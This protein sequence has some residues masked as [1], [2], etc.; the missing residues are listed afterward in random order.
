V[1][2]SGRSKGATM[3]ACPECGVEMR[4]ETITKHCKLKHKVTGFPLSHTMSNVLKIQGSNV[5]F[6]PNAILPSPSENCTFFM[7]PGCADIYSTQNCPPT[8]LENFPLNFHLLFFPLFL[9]FPSFIMFSICGDSLSPARRQ[10]IPRIRVFFR[11][12]VYSIV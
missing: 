8:T 2:G 4:A 1:S 10:L 9:L 11:H 3:R 7:F 6:L 5:C 12:N